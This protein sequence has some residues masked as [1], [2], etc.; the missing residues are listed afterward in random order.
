MPIES[1]SYLGGQ[2]AVSSAGNGEGAPP[3]KS[4]TSALTPE[5]QAEV[6][7]L[8]QRDMEVRAH[9]QAHVSAGGA[10]IKGG[11]SYQYQKGPDGKMYA[12]GGEV[13]IDT[14]PVS[15][16]PSATITKMETVKRAALAPADPSGQDRA[17]A[18][19][20]SQEETA[21]QQELAKKSTG[22][23]NGGEKTPPRPQNT[24]TPVFAYSEKGAIKASVN[25]SPRRI[26]ISA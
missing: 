16:D 6:E 15:N 10:C 2:S 24:F 20:A 25:T 17:V 12:V 3:L 26:D 11:V 19:A 23:I 4:K 1:V 21:A 13:S 9:E 7:K 5:Q 14:S 8:K 22:N 18:A